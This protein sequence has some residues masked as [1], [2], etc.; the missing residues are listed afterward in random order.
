MTLSLFP[1]PTDRENPVWISHAY[2]LKG[3]IPPALLLLSAWLVFPLDAWVSLYCHKFP[4]GHPKFLR[5]IFDNVE[6]FGHAVGVVIASLAVLRID[7]QQSKAGWTV[8]SAGLGAG[9]LAD[10]A[11]LWVSRVRPRNFDF[12]TLDA[13]AT[14]AGWLP[15]FD[16]GSGSQSFPSAH[17]ATA[18]AMAVVLSSLYPRGRML[19]FLMAV[20]VMGHRLHSGA[21]YP[22]DILAGAALGW[23]FA[24]GCLRLAVKHRYLKLENS[25]LQPETDS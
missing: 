21:H 15:W 10:F 11:K 2:S 18:F 17:A 9:L 7:R 25:P 13:N 20:L 5:N 3:L 12:S 23:L 6:P 19:F 1:S 4:A 16:A 22:S 8:L 24:L 14:I